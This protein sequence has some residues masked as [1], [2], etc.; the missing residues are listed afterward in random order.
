MAKAKK[1]KEKSLKIKLDTLYSQ[2]LRRAEANEQ[3]YITCYCGAVIP[4]QDSDCSH[5]IYRQVLSLRYD[6]RNTKASCRKCNRFMGGNLQAYSLYLVRKYGV[7][8]LEDLEKEKH[9]ITKYFPYEGE[10]KKYQTLL[11][12]L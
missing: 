9:K 8:I 3:G 4:W 2:Y 12:S 6:S 5:Y 7:G 11:K 10:I 1:P